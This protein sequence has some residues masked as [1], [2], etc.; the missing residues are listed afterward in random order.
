MRC[1]HFWKR[2]ASTVLISILPA[3]AYPQDLVLPEGTPVRLRIMHTLSSATAQE[4]NKIDFHTIDDVSVGGTIVIPK[5]SVAIA[6]ITAAEAKKRM[7]R[8]GKLSINID[9]VMLKGTDKI[10]LRGVQNLKG[11]GHT[12]AM[13][14]GMVATAIVVWPAAPFFLFMH[15]KDVTIPEGQES[16]VYTN[17]DY[18]VPRLV[19]TDAAAVAPPSAAPARN[20]AATLTNADVVKLKT[21]GLS[22][23]LI[24]QR[25]RLSSG[26]YKLD[27]DDLA[28][29]KKAGLSD[30]VI[31]EMMA[32][33]L[34]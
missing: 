8:G 4:G 19:Q 30:A 20:P 14:G 6:T 10:P 16:I 34:R 18:K 1:T 28:E 7:A 33:A 24:L 25:I 31:S 15:G 22:D 9:Y 21:I 27:P 2:T 11:G 32:A 5:D 29:L 13:T 17:T 3:L 26:N 23:E 12:G